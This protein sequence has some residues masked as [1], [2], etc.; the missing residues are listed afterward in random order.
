MSQSIARSIF[1]WI[2]IVFA[3]PILAISIVR[4]TKLRTMPLQP[5]L[6]SFLSWS[7]PDCGCGR[8]TSFDN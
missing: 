4:L 3:I 7:F 5:G 6:F 1:R 2:H 8:D